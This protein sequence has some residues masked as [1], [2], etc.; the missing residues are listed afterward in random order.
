[1]FPTLRE[2]VDGMRRPLSTGLAGAPTP[3]AQYLRMSTEH[4]K[5]SIA[6]QVDAISAYAAA[7]D[8]VI[9]RTYID[10]AKERA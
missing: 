7:H 6:N 9:I 4:Q 5:Y 1:M 8:L 10:E 2:H 3:A